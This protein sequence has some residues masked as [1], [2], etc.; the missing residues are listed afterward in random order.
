MAWDEW[1][2]L[3]VRPCD[4]SIS[5]GKKIIRCPVVIVSMNFAKMPMK[6]AKLTNHAIHERDGGI[7][8]YTGVKL[9]RHRLSVD[10]VIPKK[11]GGRD[12][13]D[14]MVTCDKEINS[15]KGH[16]TNEEAGLRLTR[17]LKEPLPVPVSAT[18]REARRPEHEPFIDR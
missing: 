12:T 15:K 13:W 2:E 5:T 11:L 16:K 4:L 8:G 6:K 3:P 9:P 18:V 7:C 14:N 17:T 1:C 10:H